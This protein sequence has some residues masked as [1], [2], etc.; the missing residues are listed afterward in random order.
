MVV[1]TAALI[2]ASLPASAQG[3]QDTAPGGKTSDQLPPIL[4]NVRYEQRLDNQVPLNLAFRDE[5]GK[6]VHLS[7][8]FAGKPVVLILAYYRCPM[9]CSQVL[10]GATHAFKQLPFRI[11]QQFNVL[12]V[13][14][15]PRETPDLA[16]RRGL[17]R[18][19]VAGLGHVRVP[20]QSPVHVFLHTREMTDQALNVQL[21]QRGLVPVRRAQD[22]EHPVAGVRRPA[23]R[24]RG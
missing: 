20:T 6:A 8:Y 14:F 13:S 21:A 9:L 1:L 2:G 19:D 16:V 22:A 5:S 4:Q 18:S 12:T 17:G 11:G 7:D 24:L 3:L 15:N 10:A 23:E